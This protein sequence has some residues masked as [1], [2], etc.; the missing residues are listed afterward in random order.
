VGIVGWLSLAETQPQL[1]GEARGG[2]KVGLQVWRWV[3]CIMDWVAGWGDRGNCRV[4]HDSY[5]RLLAVR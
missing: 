5:V 2:A 4:M 3:A 1:L